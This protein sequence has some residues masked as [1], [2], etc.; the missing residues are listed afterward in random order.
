MA[1]VA[2]IL[3]GCGYLDGAEIH[4]SVLC[5]LA[6]QQKEHKVHC[7]APDQEQ[8]R[9]VDHRTQEEVQGEKRNCLTE[10]A[11]IARGNI[12]PLTDLN[13]S[14]FDALM[15]PGGFGA[16]LNLSSFAI[17]GTACHVL[18]DFKRVVLAFHQEHKPIVAT[19]IAPAVLAKIFEGIAS[20]TMTLGTDANTNENLRALGMLPET[21][22]VNEVICDEKHRIYTTP[23]Y[24]EPDDLPGMYKGICAA[25]DKLS[26]CCSIL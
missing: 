21:A 25:V 13:P 3:S 17:E 2:L 24:M 5:L 15:I 12:S 26:T 4:E 10:A 6:L 14:S 8:R 11:R 7:F 9:V 20:I 23:A 22:K 16:A 1:N 18:D 19:C